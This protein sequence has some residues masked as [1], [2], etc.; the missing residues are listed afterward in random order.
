M[1]SCLILVG[2]FPCPCDGFQGGSNA[3]VCDACLHALSHHT[4]STAV[5]TSLN[6]PVTNQAPLRAQAVKTLFQSL[7]DSTPS[8]SQ[9]V[10]ETSNGLR[11]SKANSEAVGHLG[12]RRR[13]ISNLHNRTPCAHDSRLYVARTLTRRPQALPSDFARLFSSHVAFKQSQW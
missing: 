8:G 10:Q 4:P 12:V 13:T 2:R 11:K 1:R 7:V 9:A 6:P 3:S 5:P